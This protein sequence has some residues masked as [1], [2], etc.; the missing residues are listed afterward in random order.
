MKQL[1]ILLALALLGPSFLAAQDTNQYARMFWEQLHASCNGVME[2]EK[3]ITEVGDEASYEKETHT[4]RIDCS[5][6]SLKRID[7]ES[8]VVPG[9]EEFDFLFEYDCQNPYFSEYYEMKKDGESLSAVILPGSES[10]TPL[11]K[12][13]F[14]VDASGKLRFAESHIVKNTRL[15]D[16]DVHI[17]VWFDRDGHYE[18][19]ETR[20]MT[21]PILKKPVRTLIQA[22]LKD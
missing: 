6:G 22:Q 8:E 9:L 4:Y 7:A 15:Y 5:E 3:S 1:L 18:R 16:M 12:Q 19:H 2:W 10:E 17:Q 21:Q 20:T 14:Q 13:T 11:Q